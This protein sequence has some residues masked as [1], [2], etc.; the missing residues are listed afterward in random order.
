VT[1][2]T[3]SASTRQ[4]A[5][6][7]PGRRTASLLLEV[8]PLALTLGLFLVIGVR[9]GLPA[10]GAVR[11]V[12]GVGLLQ[13]LPG[14]LLW[15]TV[16]PITGWVL[17]DL[18]M[19]FAFGYGLA[20]ASQVVAGL[21]R[22]P[23][24][25]T[26]LPLL[27]IAVLVLLPQARRRRR[28]RRCRPLPSWYGGAL[29]LVALT[30]MPQL[31]AGERVMPLSWSTGARAAY[32]DTYFHVALASELATRG[33]R[34]FPWVAGEPLAYHW[35]SHAWLAHTAVVSHVEVDAVLMRIAPALTPVVLVAL[36]A[37]AGLRLSG[38]VLGGA[39]AALLTLGG[40]VL[41]PFGFKTISYALTPL[42]VSLG[43]AAFPLV[44]LVVVL[45]LSWRGAL[46]R[47]SAL[48]VFGLALLAAG[49][50]GSALPLC[51]AGLGTAG[52]AVLFFSRHLLRQVTRDFALVVAAL[53]VAWALV[54]KGAAGG[55]LLDTTDLLD[56]TQIGSNVG[57]ASASAAVLVLV[58]TLLQHLGRAAGVLPALRLTASR[59]E[60]LG[61]LLAGGSVAGVAA[62]LLFVQ[63]GHS[64][65]YFRLSA[66]PLMALGSVL[67]LRGLLARGRWPV[68]VGAAVAGAAFVEL[69]PLVL[70]QL[71]P[72]ELARGWAL[73]GLGFVALLVVVVAT[74]LLLRLGW[75]TTAT[76][77]LA[78]LCLGGVVQYA[79][80]DFRLAR[81]L[82]PA[83]GPVPLSRPLAVSVD[84]MTATRW[85]RRH[86]G[87]DDVV[88]TN[89]HCITPVVSDDC[90]SRRFVIAA[91]T[92]RQVLA[93]GWSYLPRSLPADWQDR[94]K[95]YP[96]WNPAL[97]ALNDGFISVPTAADARQLWD[98]GVRWVLVDTTVP[99][100][101][102]L[103]PFAA[104]RLSLPGARV[105]ALSPP[106]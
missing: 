52:V 29:G 20:V 8:G 37:M 78:S 62:N 50:K 39:A 46:R 95:V 54:F 88:M 11:V 103:A 10:W 4:P 34:T 19:G 81:N 75:R 55:L 85:I 67:G 73:L 49:S 101:P 82:P 84:V 30:S 89:R 104:L 64:E 96:F 3:L 87:L 6:A 27:A 16:R 32:V 92:Q 90:N 44:A 31:L 9:A 25:S 56:R 41:N 51:V 57:S 68:F 28:A 42:S 17:E 18:A 2:T 97:L 72:H 99:A 71:Q 65:A 105:Y 94:G 63:P 58:G 26:V 53:G 36:V 24:V 74:G 47:G 70:G 77:L 106:T 45:A 66:L 76:M 13:V 7:A 100:A 40:G 23:W 14:L 15:R 35:F 22:Q 38:V 98:R 1:S 59:V 12:L 60:P 48:L 69:P 5:T 93:E 61:W 83:A 33:P 21:S 79:H 43:F 80:Q 86:S 102:D 91:Q